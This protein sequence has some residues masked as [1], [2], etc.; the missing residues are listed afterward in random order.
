[1][2]RK[3]KFDGEVVQKTV[4]KKG[5]KQG[6]PK[7]RKELVGKFMLCIIDISNLFY[8]CSMY[9]IDYKFFCLLL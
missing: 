5:K 2:G 4:G 9:F 6:D 8:G 3:A 7:F 1:M